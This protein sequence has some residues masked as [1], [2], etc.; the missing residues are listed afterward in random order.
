MSLEVTL[1]EA[2]GAPQKPVL[3]ICAG[4][5]QRQ[6]RLEVN[7]PFYIPSSTGGKVKVALFQ[8][9]ASRNLPEVEDSRESICGIPAKLPDGRESEVQLRIRR[10]A[11]HH[12]IQDKEPVD[13]ANAARDYLSK[14]QLRQHVESLVRDVLRELPSDPYRFMVDRLRQGQGD[15]KAKGGKP[16]KVGDAQQLTSAATAPPIAEPPAIVPVPPA[17]PRPSSGQGRPGNGRP[18]PKAKS[19]NAAK[20]TKSRSSCTNLQ[21]MGEARFCITTLLRA[22]RFQALQAQDALSSMSMFMSKRI[23]TATTNKLAGEAA[24]HG[25]KMVHNEARATIVSILGSIDP[26]SPRQAAASAPAP[27][28]SAKESAR[29][30]ARQSVL[31]VMRGVEEIT[32]P[33]TLWATAFAIVRHALRLAANEASP[34]G[35]A[36]TMEESLCTAGGN[37]AAAMEMTGDPR[38]ILRRGSLQSRRASAG[39][40]PNL[41]SNA[42]IAV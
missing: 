30:E 9:F 27:A 37:W 19:S 5:V 1:L 3:A 42:P 17:A 21:E 13:E 7:R 32:S 10:G 12:K 18:A 34:H 41:N 14:H 36:V 24:F 11:G 15:D 8:Q 20:P 22:P 28:P 26:A 31:M 33:V 29:A 2:D 4:S 39:L 6:A 25:S 16:G 35:H 23:L 40:I 38:E